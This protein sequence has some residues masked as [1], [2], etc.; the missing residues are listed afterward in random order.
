MP[1]P[2]PVRNTQP[3]QVSST[4]GTALRSDYTS[5]SQ[6][7]LPRSISSN[8]SIPFQLSPQPQS[9]LSLISRTI[10]SASGRG[11]PASIA[12]YNFS[13]GSM[14][15][16]VPHLTASGQAVPPF[17][18]TKSFY[19]LLDES[20]H[21]VSPDIDAKIDKGFF[22]ADQDWTCYRRNYFSVAC[23]YKLIHPRQDVDH[24]RVQLVRSG[25]H[26]RVLGFFMCIAAK[27]DGE[28]GRSIELVQHTP[29]RDKGPMTQPEKKELKPNPTGSLGMYPNTT[30]FGTSQSI[31]NEYEIQ[32][33]NN[34]QESQNVAT[35]ERIQFKKATANNGKRR[36]AQ[37]YF[38]IVVELFAKVRKS[39]AGVEE[40]VKIAH[41]VSAQMVVRG[42]SPGHYQ[43][44]RRSSSANM[45]PG[46]G[47]GGDFGGSGRDLT[48]R[49]G[50]LGSH[51]TMSSHYAARLGHGSYQNHTHTNFSPTGPPPLPSSLPSNLNSSYGHSFIEPMHPPDL[52]MDTRNNLEDGNDYHH[53]YGNV[54]YGNQANGTRPP[55]A[56]SS[57]SSSVSSPASYETPASFLTMSPIKEETYVK[58]PTKLED[59]SRGSGYNNVQLP[60]L[61]S[62]MN[63]QDTF[64]P[65]RDCRPWPIETQRAYYPAMSAL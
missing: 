36:A 37:Q 29:K 53:Y 1:P 23:S 54:S 9:P 12:H 24:E 18:P 56:P 10:D 7:H 31:A 11:S 20:G 50:P 32:Y 63:S 52:T 62:W 3:L 60:V 16:E 13:T 61:G 6:P 47:S 33:L 44:E 45:G 17:D 25:N 34:S 2:Q 48:A 65:P 57:L 42:R 38:H 46:S 35:F 28:D 30:S 27:V 58:N 55:T 21:T 8:H 22:R 39:N 51:D 5:S 15:L 19:Q 43:D 41:R 26:E 59:H 49:G 4:I 14:H 64:Q 40:F